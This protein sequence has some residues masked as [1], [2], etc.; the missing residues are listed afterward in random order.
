MLNL[1]SQVCDIVS[2]GTIPPET[3]GNV[4]EIKNLLEVLDWR[5]RSLPIREVPDDKNHVSDDAAVEMQL[6]QLAIILFLNR[7]FK[8]LID[9]PM[10]TQR[11][12]DKAF[13]ILPRLSS[14]K[15]Q[16]PFTSF[17]VR[18]ERMSN[19]P[20]SSMSSPGPK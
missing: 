20:S 11:Y 6:Y 4:G 3:R 5:I 16:F 12:V 9:Q 1:V 10:K 15:Q 17:A 7:S 18:R 13:A 8:A 2:S 19:E 14:W